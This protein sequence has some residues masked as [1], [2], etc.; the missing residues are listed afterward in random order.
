VAARAIAFSLHGQ[1]TLLILLPLLPRRFALQRLLHPS[2]RL[3]GFP[4]G[5][6]V[7]PVLVAA[8]PT[9]AG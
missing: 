9:A 6:G 4:M 7:L 1:F 8:L 5:G 2:L 3:S